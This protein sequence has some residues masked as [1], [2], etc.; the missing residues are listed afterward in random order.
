MNYTSWHGFDDDG[1]KIIIKCPTCA[2]TELT[3]SGWVD[4]TKREKLLQCKN[5]GTKF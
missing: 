3:Q 2:S 5:C 4:D 1:N